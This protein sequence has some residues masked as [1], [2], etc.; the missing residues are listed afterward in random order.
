LAAF[1]V[2]CRHARLV[3]IVFA[4]D[5]PQRIEPQVERGALQAEREP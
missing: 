3:R 1:S 4:G 5:L 2:S